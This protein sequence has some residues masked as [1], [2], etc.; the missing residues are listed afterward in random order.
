VKPSCAILVLN[1]NGQGLLDRFLESVV[2]AADRARICDV[3]VLLVDNQST[4]GS[5]DWVRANLPQAQVLSAPA[6]RYL[7]SLNWAAEQVDC[8]LIVLLNNDVEMLPEALDPLFDTLLSGPRVFSAVPRILGM[9]RVTPNSGRWLGHFFRGR[10]A[11][12][13][14]DTV[15]RIA[16][17]LF[18]CGGAM[19]VRRRDFLTLGGFDE[20]YYPAY[21]EDVDLGYRAWKRGLASLCQPASVMYHL[22]SASM[23]ADPY[24]APHRSSVTFRNMWLFTWR[25]ISD[26]RV[27]R[28]NLYWTAR[29]YGSSL[30]R[31]KKEMLHMYHQAF[32]RWRRAV[33]ARRQDDRR[34][35]VSDREILQRV[36]ATGE[37]SP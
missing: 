12:T 29:H 14:T 15:D 23:Q 32:A 4:D 35:V 3:Q 1:H 33:L 10:M 31:G 17:T 2:T 27:L 13:L 5:R 9:D 36:R 37:L 26:R 30:R 16:P 19:A 25:N 22:G 7:Y 28:S 21:W 24:L 18:S 6:N 8:D 11:I 20:L 34:C